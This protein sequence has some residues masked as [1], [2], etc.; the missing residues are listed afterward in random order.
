GAG[1]VE[2]H[3]RYCCHPSASVE[4][5]ECSPASRSFETLSGSASLPLV[6]LISLVSC[7]GVAQVSDARRC[8]AAGVRLQRNRVTGATGTPSS[9][10]GNSS[11]VLLPAYAGPQDAWCFDKISPARRGRRPGACGLLDLLVA[12][13]ANPV[14][15]S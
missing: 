5:P 8:Y 1:A 12:G 4:S 3:L 14:A 7:I 6:G 10:I 13:D 11:A 9:Q 15:G 2:I